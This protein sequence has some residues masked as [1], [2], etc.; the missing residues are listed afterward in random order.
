MR[1]WKECSKKKSGSLENYVRLYGEEEG[2]IRFQAAKNKLYS[3]IEMELF[4][5]IQNVSEHHYLYGDEQYKFGLRKNEWEIYKKKIFYVDFMDKENKKIIEFNGDIWHANPN[6][7]EDN[8]FPNPYLKT[9]SAKSIQDIDKKR[10]E[11]Y[12]KLGYILKVVWE[13]EYLLNKEKIV[14]E[15]IDF[16]KGENSESSYKTDN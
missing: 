8:D 4:N 3:K 11:F 6:I 5:S 2:A 9:V 14:N 16:L 10:Y 13:S 7:F 15:C 12:Y 1:R